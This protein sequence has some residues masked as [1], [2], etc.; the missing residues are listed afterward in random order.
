MGRTKTCPVCGETMYEKTTKFYDYW[1]G[2]TR[3]N[4]TGEYYCPHCR[5]VAEQKAKEQAQ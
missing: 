2:I 5:D 1:T 3:V 4:H